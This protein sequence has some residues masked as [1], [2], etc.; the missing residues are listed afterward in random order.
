MNEAGS[1]GN[2]RQTNHKFAP[3]TQQMFI[4]IAALFLL[5]SRAE[6]STAFCFVLA[7]QEAIVESSI[8][9]KT[10]SS[11]AI[12]ELIASDRRGTLQTVTD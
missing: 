3:H 1:E 4:F 7:R 2:I 6:F 12:F 11:N 8:L 9:G 10:L 5:A